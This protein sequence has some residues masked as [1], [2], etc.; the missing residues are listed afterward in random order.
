MGN[1]STD[2]V[3]RVVQASHN[4]SINKP[5]VSKAPGAISWRCTW[6]STARIR[7][8][9]ESIENVTADLKSQPICTASDQIRIYNDRP[10]NCLAIRPSA[11][12]DCARVMPTVSGRRRGV[13]QPG[14]ASDS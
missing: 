3:D 12:G 11:A 10:R 2:P 9:E 14:R 6:R 7:N 13:A 1:D 4:E 5:W 8:S